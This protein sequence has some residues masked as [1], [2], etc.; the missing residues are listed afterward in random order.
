[1]DAARAKTQSQLRSLSRKK[2]K[3]EREMDRLEGAFVVVRDFAVS[4]GQLPPDY[5]STLSEAARLHHRMASGHTSK[6]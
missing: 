6:G 5:P 2:K 4:T 1:M 3:I